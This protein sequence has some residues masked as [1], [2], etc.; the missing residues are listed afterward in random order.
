MELA[1]N[2]KQLKGYLIQ[3]QGFCDSTGTAELNQELSRDRAEAVIAYLEQQADVPMRH[4]L[5][6]GAMSTVN[7]VASNQTAAG[8]AKNRRVEVTV[9]I[10]R[11]LASN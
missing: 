11:A 4:I 9:L 6:P 7:P 2:A 10:N 8:R 5:A 3:V 1:Q